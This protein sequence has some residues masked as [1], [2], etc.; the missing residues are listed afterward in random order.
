LL[1]QALYEIT[2]KKYQ[3][4]GW[5]FHFQWTYQDLNPGPKDYESRSPWYTHI[6]RRSTG[7]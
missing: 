1:L 3:P 4:K 2:S 6:N 5:Y 7:S